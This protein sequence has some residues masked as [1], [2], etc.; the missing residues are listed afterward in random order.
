MDVV[1]SNLGAP[2]SDVVSLPL[3]GFETEES[4]DNGENLNPQGVRREKGQKISKI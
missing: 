1:S 4:S 2:F 3:S